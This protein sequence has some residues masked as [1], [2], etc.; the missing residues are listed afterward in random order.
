[1]EKHIKAG[2]ASKDEKRMHCALVAW[3]IQ[4]LGIRVGTPK[5]EEDGYDMSAV[6]CT[7]LN[8]SNIKI[9]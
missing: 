4:T 7:E 2:L 3:M 8:V 9:Y 6:G 5:K 1:M